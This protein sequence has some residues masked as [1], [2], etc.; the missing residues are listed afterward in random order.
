MEKELIWTPQAENG[1]NQVVEYLQKEWSVK[2]ILRLENKII[3]L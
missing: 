1:L 2:K 3:K